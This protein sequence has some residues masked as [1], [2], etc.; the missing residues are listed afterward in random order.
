V[1]KAALNA[2]CF[3]DMEKQ[4]GIVKIKETNAKK[5]S[6]RIKNP[7]LQETEVREG[8]MVSGG[9]LKRGPAMADLQEHPGFRKA[10]RINMTLRKNCQQNK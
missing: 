8:N 5:V 1:S 3:E 7:M 4:R 10:S 9:G 2:L 6:H